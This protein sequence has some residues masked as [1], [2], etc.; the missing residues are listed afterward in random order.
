MSVKCEVWRE[1]RHVVNSVSQKEAEA[2]RQI[3]LDR[4]MTIKKAAERS[5]YEQEYLRKLVK[6]GAVDSVELDEHNRLVD[7]EDLQ[8]YLK[9]KPQRK[10]HNDKKR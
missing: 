9:E 8:R 2:L 7:W 6:K 1:Y 3:D 10:P 5:G 4:Y